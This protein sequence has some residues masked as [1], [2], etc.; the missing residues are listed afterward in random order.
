MTIAQVTRN[1][2]KVGL[3]NE[4]A[5]SEVIESLNAVHSNPATVTIAAA[6]AGTNVCEVTYTV[7]DING[8]AMT[9]PTLLTVYLSDSSAGTG[10]TATSASGTVTA[11]AASGEVFGTLTSKKALTV[12]TL[13][14]GTFVLEI[15][16]TAKTTFYPCCYIA[17]KAPTVGTIL[18]TGNYG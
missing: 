11:K 10:L 17:G 8:T 7:K 2:I 16:D 6:A 13:A 5:A 14:N 15:T 3:A 12:Q 4:S 9:V 18:A 1:A